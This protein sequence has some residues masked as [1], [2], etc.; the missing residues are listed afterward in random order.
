M[1]PDVPPDL[2]ARC[3]CSWSDEQVDEALEVGPRRERVGDVRARKAV[4]HLAPVRLQAGVHADPERRVGRE[5]QQVRQEVAQLVHQV[6][7]RLAVLDADVHVEAEDEVRARDHL[8]VLD[9]LR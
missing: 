3:R 1:R 7:Q 4:E 6:N 9:D 8:H 2:L 5:R